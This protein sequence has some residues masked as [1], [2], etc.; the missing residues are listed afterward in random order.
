[1]GILKKIKEFFGSNENDKTI[2]NKTRDNSSNNKDYVFNQSKP[3]PDEKDHIL[4]LLIEFENAVR[5]SFQHLPFNEY[6]VPSKL[7]EDLKKETMN[8]RPSVTT[9]QSILIDM[10]HYLGMKTNKSIIIFEKI[11]PSRAGYIERNNYSLNEITVGYNHL[12]GP[13]NYLSMNFYLYFFIY[14]IK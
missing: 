14:L 7:F 2:N 10:E 12:Y 9:L 13:Y 6:Q 1:M 4:N 8:G 11:D 3:S 5:I